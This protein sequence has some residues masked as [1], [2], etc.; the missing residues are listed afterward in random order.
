M[1]GRKVILE[2]HISQFLNGN[3]TVGSSLGF[4]DENPIVNIISFL[5]NTSEA[6][7]NVA[8]NILAAFRNKCQTVA[9]PSS[10]TYRIVATLS[11]G[12]VWY[13]SGKTNTYA[14]FSAKT[15]NENHN[16]RRPFMQVLLNDG[17]YSQPEVK[18]SSSTGTTETRICMRVGDS[19]IT[20]LGVIGLSVSG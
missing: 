19:N 17:S 14:S 2:A 20:P 7:W 16:T 15:I 8:T 10:S 9:Y 11:D 6:N 18:L 12:T 4:A 3:Y 13:D 5:N 1:S